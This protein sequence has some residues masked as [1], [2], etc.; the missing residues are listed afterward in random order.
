MYWLVAWQQ[1]SAFSQ[2]KFFLF[3]LNFRAKFNKLNFYFEKEQKVPQNKG[4]T[5]IE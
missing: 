2:P 3:S 5:E 1:T 4:T